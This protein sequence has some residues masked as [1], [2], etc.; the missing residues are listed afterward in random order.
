MITIYTWQK[1][2][3]MKEEGFSIKEIARTFKIPKNT[4]KKYI[5]NSEPLKFHK[6]KVPKKIDPYLAY[7]SHDCHSF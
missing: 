2:K 4:V 1:I 6:P 5:R 3:T 7:S